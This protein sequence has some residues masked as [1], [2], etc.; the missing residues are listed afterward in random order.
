MPDYPAK[1]TVDYPA[2]LSRGKLLL[3]TFFGWA[4]VGIP[5]GICLGLMGIA[6]GFVMFIAW[7]IVL[8]TG[9]YPKGMFDFVLGYYRWG[10]RVGAYMGFMTDVY[11]P[12]SGKE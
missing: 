6:A 10:M 2:S 7:W 8:F 12:F 9:K 5:H 3:R 4:Y 11:P 1:V